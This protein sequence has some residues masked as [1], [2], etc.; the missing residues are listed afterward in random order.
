VGTGLGTGAGLGTGGVTTGSQ[1]VGTSTG[2]GGCPTTYT[3]ATH[4][5]IDVGWSGSLALTKG[6]GQVHLWSKSKFV[7]SGDTAGVMSRS[8]GSILPEI[9]TSA[10]AGGYSV[11]PE[12]PDTAWDAPSMPIFMGTATRQ[13]TGWRVNPGVALMGLS[14]VD[15]NAEWPDVDKITGIDVDDDGSAG[16]TAIPRVG[17]RFAA[18]P[19]NLSQSA[20]VDELHLAS[21]NIM[22]LQSSTPGCP[23]R[24]EGMAEVAAFDSHVICCHI[25]GGAECTPSQRDFVDSNRTVYEVQGGRF[26]SQRISDDAS[27]DEVRAVLPIQ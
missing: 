4:I 19:A 24:Q 5:V 16:V 13:P 17:G 27:C 15:A 26:T 1:G 7:E 14:M 12:I 8:C 10:L 9:K 6:S 23:E 2:A 18:P 25:A 3:V 22:T 20:R 11:L 21:H